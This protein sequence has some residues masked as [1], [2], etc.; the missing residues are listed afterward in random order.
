MFIFLRA[1]HLGAAVILLTLMTL[2]GV[3]S[4]GWFGLVWDWSCII[5]SEEDSTRIVSQ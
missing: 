3:P 2:G 4:I 1:P 5:V